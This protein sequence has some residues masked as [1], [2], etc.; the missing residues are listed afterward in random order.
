[1]NNF[2]QKK[3]KESYKQ[4]DYLYDFLLPSIKKETDTREQSEVSKSTKVVVSQEIA[5]VLKQVFDMPSRIS[6][7]EMVKACANN[8]W[9]ED[10]SIL[11]K[12]SPDTMVEILINGYEAETLAP[13][14]KQ[15]KMLKDLHDAFARSC[16]TVDE[17]YAYRMGMRDSLTLL[18]YDF[19]WLRIAKDLD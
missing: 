15:E 16:N 4:W 6:K 9:V 5:D 2:Y 12:L 3:A 11:N 13:E 8:Y 14:Q 19:N 7:Y 17:L 10:F 1:M 18:G